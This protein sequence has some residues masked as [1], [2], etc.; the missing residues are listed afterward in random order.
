MLKVVCNNKCTE[1]LPTNGANVIPTNVTNTISTD[2][3]I[4]VSTNFHN[5]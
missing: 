5:K 1:S 4:S 2:V 3:M